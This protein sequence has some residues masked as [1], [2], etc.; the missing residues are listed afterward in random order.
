MNATNDRKK[1][2]K[3]ETD[4]NKT[5]IECKTKREELNKLQSTTDGKIQIRK[6]SKKQPKRKPGME[7]KSRAQ[8]KEIK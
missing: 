2:R 1:G 8:R 6:R 3:E 7:K 5:K 4:R